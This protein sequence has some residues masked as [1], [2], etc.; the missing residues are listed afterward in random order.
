MDPSIAWLMNAIEDGEASAADALF[1]ALHAELHRL[2]KRE[3][4]R[5]EAAVSLSPTSLLHEAYLDM[6]G[7]EGTSFPGRARFIGYAVR[8]M[9]GLV[10]DHARERHAQKRGGQFEITA[11]DPDVADNAVDHQNPTQISDALDELGKRAPGLAEVVDLKLFCGFSFVE[12]AVLRNVSE[13]TVQR[14]W[15]K[16][17]IYLH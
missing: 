12:I 4:A 2:P 10:I 14:S 15:E 9:R 5:P 3:L 1:C 17:R 7:R 16:A 8:V 6:S 11:L 13:R